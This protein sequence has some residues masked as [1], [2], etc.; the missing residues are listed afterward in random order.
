MNFHQIKT[1]KT[2]YLF[3]IFTLCTLCLFTACGKSNTS[4]TQARTDLTTEHVRGLYSGMMRK[5]IEDLLGTSDSSLAA[6]ETIEVYS[7]ADGSTAVL[8]YHEDTLKGAYIRDKENKE[9]SLFD[10]NSN[11]TNNTNN[12]TSSSI[13][14]VMPEV[15]PESDVMDETMTNQ[16]NNDNTSETMVP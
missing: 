3:G 11:N 12:S 1:F 10:N 5:D 16:N 15:L 2:K 9:T 13:S 8:R 7:L 4:G 6:K 14:D